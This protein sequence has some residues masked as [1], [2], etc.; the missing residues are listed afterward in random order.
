MSDRPLRAVSV[1][2]GPAVVELLP[3]LGAALSG[4]GP[5][6]APHLPDHPQLDLPPSLAD[7]EDDPDDP[8]VAVVATSGSTR[9]PRGVLLQASALLASA[10]ATHDRLGGPG[11]WLL[12]LPVHHVAGLQLLVRSLISRTTPVVMDL[13]E[14]F[15]PEAFAAAARG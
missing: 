11:R 12:A 2:S 1:V 7:D 15:D 3:A 4:A 13:A 8:T 6:L 14:G 5:V 10:S 9:R